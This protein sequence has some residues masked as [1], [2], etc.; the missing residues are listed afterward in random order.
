MTQERCWCC[1]DDAY[2]C[3]CENATED[4]KQCTMCAIS[5]E[6]PKKKYWWYSYAVHSISRDTFFDNV[7]DAHPFTQ[8]PGKNIISYKEITKDD[9]E[10]WHKQH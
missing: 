4:G 6:T 10:L 3:S 8:V 5:E 7:I 9:Y 2:K 1:G